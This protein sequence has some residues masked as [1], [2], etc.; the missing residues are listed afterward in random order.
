MHASNPAQ[1]L[2]TTSVPT[3]PVTIS[4]A[5]TLGTGI[6]LEIHDANRNPASLTP[7]SGILR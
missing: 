6:Q 1:V 7:L 4:R 2:T 5:P 3:L